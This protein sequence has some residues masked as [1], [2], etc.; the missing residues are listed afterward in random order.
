LKPDD[1]LGVRQAL[2]QAFRVRG[3]YPESA[4]FFSEGALRWS[5]VPKWGRRPVAEALPPV[6]ATVTNPTSG[7]REELELVFASATRLTRADQDLNGLILR[8]YAWRNAA[9]LGFD[10]NP[11]LPP[12]RRPYAPSFHQVFRMSADGT[13]RVDMVVELVQTRRIPFDQHFP[14]AT[15]PLR[16]GVTLIIAAPGDEATGHRM[17]PTVRFAI[18]KP[19]TGKEGLLREARQRDYCLAMGLMNGDTNDERHFKANFGLT[20]QGL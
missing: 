8:E 6:R 9:R 7:K 5:R 13:L 17:P 14:G 16:G 15:F 11:G 20:H 4:S 10:A 18:R 2:M 3:I 1:D 12:E 19:L